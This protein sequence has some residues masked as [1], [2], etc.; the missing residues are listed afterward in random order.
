MF[1][2]NNFFQD[3]IKEDTDNISQKSLRGDILKMYDAMLQQQRRS[4][5]SQSP[6]MVLKNLLNK[7]VSSDSPLEQK[8]N[9]SMSASMGHTGITFN[10]VSQSYASSISHRQT[11][12][13]GFRHLSK[14]KEKLT[15]QIVLQ[16]LMV[17]MDLKIFIVHMMISFQQMMIQMYHLILN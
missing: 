13:D 15:M 1:S 8:S 3:K 4:I 14:N 7:Q 6:S 12:D 2:L 5:P 11:F 9:T 17:K 10:H 16:F